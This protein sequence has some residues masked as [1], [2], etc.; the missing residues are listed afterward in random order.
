MSAV[1]SIEEKNVDPF[2]KR[3]N[4]L[5]ELMEEDLVRTVN[6]DMQL[7]ISCIN[8]EF[9]EQLDSLKPF[10]KGNPVPV[11]IAENLK[12]LGLKII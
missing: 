6:I 9:V 3:I 12:V 11:F 10:G 7:P 4:E 1:I 5:C 2:R 8:K